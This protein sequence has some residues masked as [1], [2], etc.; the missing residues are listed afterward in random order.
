MATEGK[1]QEVANRIAIDVVK[2]FNSIPDAKHTDII[3]NTSTLVEYIH[4]L[5]ERDLVPSTII[6]KL[7]NLRLCIEYLS[8]Y[9]LAIDS[10]TTSSKCEETIKWLQKR[11]KIL[12]KDVRVQQFSNALK[13]ENEVDNASNPKE[14]WSNTEVKREVHTILKK[15]ETSDL[16]NNEHLTVLSYLA[17]I[18][19]YKNSQRP[20]VVE[21]MTISE[22]QQRR[23]QGNSKVLIRVLKHKTCTSTGPANIIINKNC[24]QV[25]CQYHDLIRSKIVAQ[26]V[27][28]SKLFFLTSTG[29][30][31]KKVSE[32]IQK[33]AGAHNISVPTAS[34]HRK[35]TKTIAHCDE[36]TTEGTMRALN[37]HTSHSDATSSKFYQ[38]PAAKTAVNV[39]NTI[40]QLSKKRFFTA[41][42][43]R[44]I[45]KEWPVGKGATPPLELCRRISEKYNIER[46]AKQLQDRWLTLSK[47]AI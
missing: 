39:Y 25:M 30:A 14:F 4:T 24:E 27:A 18:L 16:T 9:K 40:K 33:V 37:R 5:K 11:A 47:K 8:T 12:R 38:L 34:L 1:D 13:G 17:A 6:D 3:L 7:R 42:E 35:V 2:F 43:D 19:M 10:T 46:T 29:N 32:T 26:S 45:T 36:E 15:A 41:Q 23:D 20:G 22:F 44:I 28:L 21:N 31:F